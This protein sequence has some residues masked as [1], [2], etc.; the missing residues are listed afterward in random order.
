M[1]ANIKWNAAA[2]EVQLTKNNWKLSLKVN[3]KH[4]VIVEK[5]TL[6]VDAQY[7]ADAASFLFA[8]DSEYNAIIMSSE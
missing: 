3:A 2:K 7:L 1:G 5:G 4:T 8:F 6:Y